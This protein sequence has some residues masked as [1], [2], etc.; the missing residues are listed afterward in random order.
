MTR[1]ERAP[2][3]PP[4]VGRAERV[5]DALYRIAEAASAAQDLGEFYA[6]M[7]AIVGELMYAENFF[8]ALYDA[9]RDAVNYPY[10]V[11]TVDPEV[12]DP[13]AWHQMGTTRLARG[14]TAYILRTGRPIHLDIKAF[15][16]LERAGRSR[17]SAR[18]AKRAIL[19]APR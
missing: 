18:S 14:T 15:R 9:E 8:I 4:P 3:P 16:Q 13:K 10:N 11:D 5:Q 17:L 12:I 2:S 7:H 1:T 19:S 6:D